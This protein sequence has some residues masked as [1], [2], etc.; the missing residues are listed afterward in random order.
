[1]AIKY[2]QNE[3]LTLWI[4]KVRHEEH[5]RAIRELAKGRQ[6]TE[7]LEE[8]SHRITNKILHAFIKSMN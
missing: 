2:R 5:K 3:D 1:M 6:L 4:E 8:M 7:V